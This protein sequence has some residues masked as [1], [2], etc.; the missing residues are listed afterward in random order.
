MRLKVTGTGMDS[1]QE[2][3]VLLPQFS[4]QTVV[5]YHSEVECVQER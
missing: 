1:Y 5:G 2:G 3:E 4:V